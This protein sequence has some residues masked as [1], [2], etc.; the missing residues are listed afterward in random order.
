MNFASAVVCL[1]GK[2]QV[3]ARASRVTLSPRT[4]PKLLVDALRVLPLGAQHAQ[5][6]QSLCCLAFGTAAEGEVLKVG[7][8]ERMR[9]VGGGVWIKSLKGGRRLNRLGSCRCHRKQ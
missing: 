9:K 8:Q 4:A 3:E 5:A 7:Q 1:V 6:P 2:A